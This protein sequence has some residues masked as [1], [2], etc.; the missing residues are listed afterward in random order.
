MIQR[1]REIYEKYI[2]IYIFEKDVNIRAPSDG[3]SS[4]LPMSKPICACNFRRKLNVY[5]YTMPV[6]IVN[7]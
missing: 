6:K 2:N 5:K 3:T 7:F 1:E 4:D